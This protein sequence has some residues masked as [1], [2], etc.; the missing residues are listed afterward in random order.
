MSKFKLSKKAI[1]AVISVA[2]AAVIIC[3]LLIVN[4]FYPLRYFPA[5]VVARERPAE[6]ELEVA[7]LDV[8]HA[9]CAIV[10]FPNGSTMLID[11]GDGSYRSNL[12]IL[13]ELNRRDIDFIDYVVC[14][15]VEE[16]Y[17]GG[18]GEILRNKRV[19]YIFWP[20]CL[21]RYISDGFADFVTSASSAL[22]SYPDWQDR[23]IISEYSAGV[24]AGDAFFTF[25]S[26]SLHTSP[27]SEYSHLNSDP[28][29]ENISAASAVIWIEYAGTGIVYAGG[30]SG[31]KLTEIAETYT[32]MQELGEE[33]FTFAGHE[34]NFSDCAAYKVASHGS[35]NARSALF[36]D[37]ISPEISVISVGENNAEGSPAVATMSDL[38]AHGELFIT[39]YD[40][41]VTLTIKEDGMLSASSSIS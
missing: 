11:G 4:I 7:V 10:T 14:T 30:V 31:A 28:S 6:G 38:L 13:T 29:E 18:L 16:E 33:Y 20:Y 15:S 24:V 2:C 1:A 3:T 34:I 25:L 12:K 5:Y 26:P 22:S 8:G 27:E 36:T 37:L 19:G 41:D 35:D 23:M 21:N 9:D 17:C 40:G 32:L 39:Q